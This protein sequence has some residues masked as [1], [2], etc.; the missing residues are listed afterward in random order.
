MT[1]M[2]YLRF[3]DIPFNGKSIV[4]CGDEKIGEEA[5]VSVYVGIEIDGKIHVVLPRLVESSCVS[6]SGCLK[7]KMY[8][9]VGDLVGIGSDGEPLLSNVHIVGIIEYSEEK[10]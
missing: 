4:M 9:V 3:G 1:R 8:E 5:G 7:R 10:D 6:L 2:M